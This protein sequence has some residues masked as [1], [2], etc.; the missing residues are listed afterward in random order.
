MCRNCDSPIVLAAQSGPAGT[1]RTAPRPPEV[2]GTTVFRGGKLYTLDPGRPW[3]EAVAVRGRDIL[4]VG[5][6]EDVTAAAGSGARVVDLDGRML[7]PGFVEAHIHP[8]LGGLLTSGVDLQLPTKDD[9]LAAI[10]QYAASHPAG[11]VRGFGWRMDMVGPEGPHRADLDA[12]I[13]DRPALLF[14][15]D[16]HSAWVNSATLR[17][18]G[19]TRDTPDPVPG[20]SYYARD[21]DG[22]P[23]G[24]VLEAPALLALLGAIDPPTPDRLAALFAEWAAKAA[25]AGIT[26]V[27]DAGMPPLGDDPDGLADVYTDAET[28]GA[29]PFRVVVAHLVKDPP[30]EDA[31][32]A[33][34]RLRDRL[35]TELV[36]GGVLKIVGD[37][38]LEGH[39]GYLFEP[40][41]DR[42]DTCGQTP[43]SEEQWHR[44]IAEADAAGVDVHIHSIGDRTTRIALDAIAAAIAANP[45]RDRRHAI[46][47][48]ELVDDADL[49][50]F[51]ELGVIGQFSA[52]WMAA[53]PSNTG[54]VQQRV[55]PQRLATIYRPR[56]L[57]DRGA[58][59]AFGS[60]WPA[61][62]WVS[63]YRPLDAIETAVTRQSVGEPDMAVLEPADERLDLAQAL[64]AATLGAARQLRLDDL[65]GSIEP[66]K[67]ADLVVLGANLF[68]IEP[69]RIAATEV[70]MTMMNGRFTHGG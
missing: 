23:T 33:T 53:D 6:D 64:H 45:A 27:F 9:A 35:G 40:Y 36:H 54:T 42:P 8:L 24:F 29:L 2:E 63:T 14:A 28:R 22:E 7:L 56:A 52:N 37:G 17:A 30:I 12:M 65:I 18:A 16:A 62:G 57:L 67:R 39:T 44:L 34:L 41:A 5:S 10:A 60:D 51:G 32:A 43:F 38:G 68:D 49:P 69:H 15:I 31:V 1:E 70:E 20:F 13:P 61:S 26:A 19:I 59:I 3:A 47:H 11:V 25:A 4:A 21:A 55:G 58:T 50:R 46:A 66:G 48:L